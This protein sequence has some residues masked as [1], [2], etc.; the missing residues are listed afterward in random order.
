ME[1]EYMHATAPRFILLIRLYLH[2]TRFKD[3]ILPCLFAEYELLLHR[4]VVSW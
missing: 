2:L 1:V 3:I 4:V